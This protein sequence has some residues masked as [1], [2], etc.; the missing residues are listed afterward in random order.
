VVVAGREGKSVTVLD[1][2]TGAK[3][4]GPAGWKWSDG[5]RLY[6]LANGRVG[7]RGTKDTAVAVWDLKAGKPADPL[8][9]PLPPA[10]KDE[11]ALGDAWLSPDGRYAALAAA[12]TRVVE[13]ATG[14]LLASVDWPA[15]SAAFAADGR[16]V[17]LAATA[18]KH[19]W[20]ELPSGDPGPAWG[21]GPA[22]AALKARGLN[23]SA[24][25]T[26][27]G[28][29]NRSGLPPPLAPVVFDW[30][31]GN[32]VRVLVGGYVRGV[33]AAVSADGRL[34]AAL[35]SP[36]ADG[37]LCLDVVSTADGRVVG[38]AVF[39]GRKTVPLFFF[40]A[41]GRGLVVHEGDQNK[42]RWFDLPPVPGPVGPK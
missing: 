18:G 25:G 10:G 30:K 7:F 20:F 34:A 8:P 26:R 23:V 12:G 29:V 14:K 40:T 13:R 37:T 17:L 36:G 41:D 16:R 5:G 42:V 19:R 15:Y 35:R 27:V 6:V 22:S 33:P 4:G 39:P 21:I 2:D 9:L 3:V 1:A 31:T 11:P 28:S 32:V 38:R 24:D